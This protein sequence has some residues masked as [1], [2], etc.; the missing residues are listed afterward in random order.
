MATAAAVAVV[1]VSV[2]AL[3]LVL[4]LALEN[5]THHRDATLDELGWH[6]L[7]RLWWM[8]GNEPVAFRT[9]QQLAFRHPLYRMWVAELR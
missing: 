3:L 2:A 8:G 5:A 9:R 4:L 6:V 1:A 7:L